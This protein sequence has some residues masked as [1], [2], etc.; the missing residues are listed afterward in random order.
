MKIKLF[1]L[2]IV[3]GTFF[4]SSCNDDLHSVGTT[5]QPDGDKP[6]VYTDTFL[7]KASTVLIDSIY[8]KT[9][10]GLLGE[11]YDPLYGNLRSDYI[12]QFYCP[13]D[14]FKFAHE[15]LDGKIDSVNFLIRYDS[16][17][18]DSLVPMQVQLYKVVKPLERNYYTN[19]NPLN[20]CDMQAS[21]GSQTYTAFDRTIPDSVRFAL[22]YN[23][24]Y[25]FA[26]YV[27]VRMP[28]EFGQAF[29]DET[30]YRQESF[31][32]QEAFNAFLPGIYVTTTFG[33]GNMLKVGSSYLDF[34][35]RYKTA[36]SEGQDTII[37][38]RESFSVTKEVIQMNSIKNSDIDRLVQPDDNYTY[39][40]T[41]AGVFTRI[42]IPAKEIIAKI[43][44]RTINNTYFTL[45]SMPQEN[46]TYALTPPDRL[47]IL[48]E[49]SV[50]TFFESGQIEN[51]STSFLS[52][53]YSATNSGYVFG[54]I[55]N[56]LKYQ[57][58]HFPDQDLHLLV[59]PVRRESVSD[60]N[61]GATYTT[62]LYNYLEPAG[63]KLRKDEEKMKLQILT[64]QYAESN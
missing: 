59:I 8:A 17:V 15:A 28:L 3:S 51:N 63:V 45:T 36:G 37:N 52:E 41:P 61:T 55:A 56:M 38:S 26:P 60:S 13:P 7:I 29:Y 35:Y 64:S 22:D 10:S 57:M 50:K 25:L 46:W 44:G 12:C 30:I 4:L 5:I 42:V 19:A 6:V 18:G 49:D 2:G 34:Y 43:K 20:Y 24:N 23:G 53:S 47:L 62:A 11:I 9:S 40:K 32:D 48:P 21:F 27:R 39:L 1:I 16:W 58:E 31:K 14:G 33:S 54:N